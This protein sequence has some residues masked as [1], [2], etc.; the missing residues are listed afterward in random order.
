MGLSFLTP[1][2]LGGAALVAVPIVLHLAMRRKPV[3]HDF[4]ALR[5]LQEKRL[6]NR[7]RL[8]LNH[9]LLLLLRIAAIVLLALA[10]ARPTLRAAGWLGEA[11]G[12]VAVAFVFDTAPRMLLRRANRTRLEDAAAIARELLAK[13]PKGSDVAV[14]DTSGRPLSFAASLNAARAAMDRLE[15]GPPVMP[16]ATAVDAAANLLAESE[17]ERRE[18]YL[19][20]DLSIAAWEVGE[21]AAAVLARHADVAPVVVD[22]GV[23]SPSNFSLDS[24]RLPAERVSATAPLELTVQRS[25][26]GPTEERSV[27]VEIV[28]P[29]GTYARRAVQPVSWDAV[30]CEPL[31]FSIAG[32]EKGTQQGRVVIVG[33]DDLDAD[34][35]RYFSVAVDATPTVLVASPDPS[36]RT[37]RFLTEAIA[38]AALARDGRGRLGCTL[39]STD[40]FQQQGWDDFDGIVLVDPPPL[41]ERTWAQLGDWVRFGRGLVIWLGPN[42]RTPEAFNSEESRRTLGGGLARIWRDESGE[43]HLT[44]RQLDHPML[45]VFRRVADSVPWQDFPVYRHW[46]FVLPPEAAAEPIVSYRDGT[47]AV[48]VHPLGQGTVVVITTPVSQPAS[49]PDAWNLLATGFEPWPFVVL[50]N[51]S[52]LYAMNTRE[53]HNVI[54][55]QPAT[56]RVPSDLEGAVVVQTPADDEFPAAVDPEQRT[57]TVSSTR[58]PGNYQILAG[59]RADGFRGGFSANLPVVATDCRRL[60]GERASEIFGSETPLVRTGDEIVREVRLE[61]VGTEL[62]GWLIILVALVMAGDW[63]VANRFYAPREDSEPPSRP[64]HDFEAERAEQPPPLAAA[65]QARVDREAAESDDAWDDFDD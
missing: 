63:M 52:L 18:L 19:F 45:A 7:R 57:I 21:P 38:P 28:Q 14:V 37:G 8:Q 61:R 6:A 22:V 23:E 54:T 47:P 43:N 15:A 20:T 34:N 65:S 64:A 41:D 36:S 62:S 60:D 24:V 26:I 5:F 30:D 55:G 59:G 11:E 1:L 2:L 49:D 44:P 58:E 25:R 12:P 17:H 32:L 33:A 50:A 35:V 53:E 40:E 39:V 10:L 4:P 46:E 42:A 51:E 31:V 13:L 3:P 9:L 27:A 56:V 48:L 16:L 29:D